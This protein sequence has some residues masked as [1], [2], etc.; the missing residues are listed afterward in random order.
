MGKFL[1]SWDMTGL[2]AVVD[3]TQYEDWDKQVTWDILS[4]KDAKQ[5]PLG[6]IYNMMM[7]RAR[8]NGHRHYEIYG[9]TADEG[10]ETDDIRNMFDNDPQIA[11]D[12]VRRIGVKLY[13]DRISEKVQKIT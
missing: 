5:N 9:L 13:S 12:A 10:I 4:G 2:E 3:I 8:F 11:A 6:Q 1:V 7:L